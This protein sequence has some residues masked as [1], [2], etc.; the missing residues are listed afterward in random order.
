MDKEQ[1]DL[2]QT[3]ANARFQQRALGNDFAQDRWMSVLAQLQQLGVRDAQRGIER[4]ISRFEVDARPYQESY[5][6]RRMEMMEMGSEAWSGNVRG[7]AERLLEG[8]TRELSRV[9]SEQARG[10]KTE[11]SVKETLHFTFN[12]GASV[13]SSLS[14]EVKPESGLVKGGKA[15]EEAFSLTEGMP[16]PK[17]QYLEVDGKRFEV[18]RVSTDSWDYRVRDIEELQRVAAQREAREVAAVAEK[19][20]D[21]GYRLKEMPAV[22]SQWSTDAQHAFLKAYQRGVQAQM[23]RLDE[24]ERQM[25]RPLD[26]REARPAE[27]GERYSGS[28]V[29]ADRDTIAQFN[30]TDKTLVMHDRHR[31]A[32]G[33]EWAV[34]GKQA[35]VSYS[36]GGTAVGRDRE[37]ALEHQGREV[38][39][40]HNHE[41]SREAGREHAR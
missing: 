39:R 21:H 2:Q 5:Q 11:R 13:G 27:P 38:A 30:E 26:M 31:F 19:M 15:V 3:I 28:V 1:L 12:D 33:S 34:E 25:G 36:P 24:V 6:E 29:Y 17:G 41:S 32:N 8:A 9:E 4:D 23:T 37:N 10:S 16:G 7:N 14:V 35:E 20:H 18:E 22:T 40:D